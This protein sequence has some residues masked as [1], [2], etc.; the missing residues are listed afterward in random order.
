MR[1]SSE[2]PVDDISESVTR[3]I[4]TG[5]G[6]SIGLFLSMHVDLLVRGAY[7]STGPDPQVLI[8]LFPAGGIAG[9]LAAWGLCRGV[10]SREE[11]DRDANRTPYVVHL[12]VLS[13]V[14]VVL[15]SLIAPALQRA[16]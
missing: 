3:L 2:N 16:R 9:D 15:A 4:G 8:T 14:L 7:L 5:A 10:E 11:T 12:V 1:G 6:A 13:A